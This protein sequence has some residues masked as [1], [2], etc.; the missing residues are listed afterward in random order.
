MTATRLAV[1]GLV[2]LAS[3]TRSMRDVP[4]DVDDET[5]EPQAVRAS[6]ASV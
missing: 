2:V 4:G 6:A 3:P 1:G 5:E